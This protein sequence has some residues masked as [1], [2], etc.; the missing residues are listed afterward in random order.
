MGCIQEMRV[1]GWWSVRPRCHTEAREEKNWRQCCA[2]IARRHWLFWPR[3]VEYDLRSQVQSVVPQ[4]LLKS[5]KDHS[6]YV[7]T[8]QWHE[9]CCFIDGMEGNKGY[10]L[11]TQ[12]AH[13]HQPSSLLVLQLVPNHLI[14]SR[15]SRL[16][17]QEDRDFCLFAVWRA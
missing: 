13:M 5:W 8:L 11:H 3:W 6:G 1:W 16:L 2:L 7:L 10:S 17:G 9:L 4:E 14:M 15:L 12:H